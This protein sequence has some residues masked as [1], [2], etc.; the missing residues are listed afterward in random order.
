[1]VTVAENSAAHRPSVK[2]SMLDFTNKLLVSPAPVWS[3]YLTVMATGAT[4]D[5]ER[6]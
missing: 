5:D 4:P 3:L 6:H 2:H 1:M